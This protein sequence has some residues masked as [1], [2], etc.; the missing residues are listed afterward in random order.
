MNKIILTAYLPALF[1]AFLITYLATPVIKKI[2]IKLGIFDH[3]E[4]RKIHTAPTPLLGGIAIYLGCVLSLL[5]SINFNTV[6]L[7]IAAV[8]TILLIIGI[9]DDIWGLSPWLKLLGQ[10]TCAA[11]TFYFGISIQFVSNFTGGVFYLGWLAMPLTILW[12]VAIMNTI[13]L[14]DGLDGLA[15]GITAISAAMLA[16]VAIHT[17]QFLAALLAL[18]LLGSSLGFL[19]YNFPKAQIFMGDSGSMF[20]GYIL[21]ITSI[22]GV[23]KSTI[24]IS[25]AVPLLI[26]GIPILDTLFAIFRRL[27]NRKNIFYADNGHFHHRLI[28]LGLTPKQ[29]VLLL[30]LLSSILGSFGLILSFCTGMSAYIT[31]TIAIVII[32]ITSIF[33]RKNWKMIT[34]ENQEKQ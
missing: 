32:V 28:K 26:L 4:G 25:L 34:Y 1:V 16:I 23:L 17:N 21:G 2:S 6:T 13:N 22:L 10:I 11:F 12:L 7:G 24:T 14:I 18:T 31:L 15:S 20:L 29:V 33:L 5:V 27:K 8:S 19:R 3:P 30:Y 9:L